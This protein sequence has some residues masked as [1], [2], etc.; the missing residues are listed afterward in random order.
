MNNYRKG[1]D[2][3]KMIINDF[4]CLVTIILI[5]SIILMIRRYY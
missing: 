4:E 3:K 5:I 2:K 1:G